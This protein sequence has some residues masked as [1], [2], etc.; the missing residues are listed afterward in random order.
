MLWCPWV[1]PGASVCWGGVAL[2]CPWGANDYSCLSRL[3]VQWRF[4]AGIEKQFLALQ[5]GFH[6]LIP[7]EL[8]KSFDEKELELVISGLGKVDVS[9]WK[10]NTRLKHCTAESDVV[11][12]FWKV[13]S[14]GLI[15][16]TCHDKPLH[17]GCG[18][19]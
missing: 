9:D 3:Y 14:H 5:T 17:V 19:L 1:L 18:V 4:R 15:W 8:L 11:K 7:P 12:W 6:E 13:W 16:F 2:R 10:A